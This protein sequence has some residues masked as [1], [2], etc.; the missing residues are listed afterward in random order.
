MDVTT[1]LAD[2]QPSFTFQMSN[3][4]IR[5]EIYRKLFHLT[6]IIFPLGILYLG[7]EIMLMLVIPAFIGSITFEVMRAKV[8]WFDRLF[9]SYFGGLMR[10]YE[11]APA[12]RPVVF[13]GA[14]WLLMGAVICCSF[15][16]EIVAAAA[17][18]MLVFGDATAAIVGMHFGRLRFGPRRKSV[19]GS[20]AFFVV[21]L[22]AAPLVGL[23]I[24]VVLVGALAATLAEAAGTLLDD[25]VMVPVAAALAM[26]LVYETAFSYNL[27]VF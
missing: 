14:S 17:F 4:A 2:S 9:T 3:L 24:V 18:V 22:I 23:P 16:T 19:E 21:S 15:F 26:A 1:K 20:V 8:V 10:P 25:N 11:C 5:E 13:T 7:N 27:P 6:G 12:P